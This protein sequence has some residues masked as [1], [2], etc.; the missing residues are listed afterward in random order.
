VAGLHDG[1]ITLD[2]NQPGL[3]VTVRLPMLV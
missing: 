1:G 3:R 2:A